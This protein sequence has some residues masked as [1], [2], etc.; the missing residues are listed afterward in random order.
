MDYYSILGVSKTASQEEIKKAYRKLAMKHHPD[1]GGDAE[2]SAKINE[3]YTVLG[4]PKKRA[5]YDNPQPEF[6]FRTSGFGNGDPFEDIFAQA[7]GFGNPRRRQ[8]RNKN[9]Q[10]QYTLDMQDCFTGKG[11]T[12]SYNLPSGRTET[13]DVKIPPGAKDG[14]AVQFDGYGDDSVTGLPRGKLILQIRVKKDPNWAVNGSDL[15]TE[16]KIPVW[17]L[18]TGTD[19]E[20]DTPEGKVISLRVPA[21]AQSGTHFSITGHGL[22]HTRSPQRGKLMIKVTGVVPKITDESLKRQIQDLQDEINTRS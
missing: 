20:I 10:L 1:R 8:A 14:D 21:G 22:P 12:L 17:D 19:L 18:M 13:I 7:F 11:V 16:K 6:N 15:H 9:I 2:I 5:E 4:D 3:A